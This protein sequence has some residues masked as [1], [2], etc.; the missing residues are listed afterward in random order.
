MNSNQGFF[1]MI[2]LIIS[3]SM[4]SQDEKFKNSM[5]LEYYRPID[6]NLDGFNYVH[7][8]IINGDNNVS[9]FTTRKSEIGVGLGYER[10]FQ[11][12]IILRVRAGQGISSLSKTNKA[13]SAEESQMYP[14]QTSTYHLDQKQMNL[15][16]GVGKRT[17]V[18]SSLTVD[19]GI[20]IASANYIKSSSKLIDKSVL[21]DSQGQIVYLHEVVNVTNFGDSFLFGVGPFTKIEL[22]VFRRIY[23]SAEFQI[24]YSKVFS[25]ENSYNVQKTIDKYIDSPEITEETISRT[26]SNDI[27]QWNW[28][29]L[30]P[31]IRISYKF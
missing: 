3:I 9:N 26:I 12:D 23:A 13:S 25:H 16:V 27:Q 17:K 20:E 30:S 10:V 6:S 22:R 14:I 31:L 1:L 4:H 18:F 11:Q 19:L 24:Y 28:S 15:F 7:N 21:E 29:K 8:G 2:A 5:S